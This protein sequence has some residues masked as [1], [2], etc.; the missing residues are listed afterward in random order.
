M[1][2]VLGLLAA[3]VPLSLLGACHDIDSLKTCRAPG[4]VAIKLG[5]AAAES[6]ITPPSCKGLAE[7]CG[8]AKDDSCCAIAKVDTAE[9]F[10]VGYDQGSDRQSGTPVRGFQ[11]NRKTV[12]LSEFWLDRYEVTVGRFRRFVTDYDSWHNLAPTNRAGR[13]PRRPDDVVDGGALPDAWIYAWRE[14]PAWVPVNQETLLARVN[15]DCGAANPGEPAAGKWT[16]APGA[17]EN[18]PMTCVS[19]FE[20]FMFCIWD[21]A[22][23]PSEAEWSYAAT[24]GAQQRAF[25]WSQPESNTNVDPSLANVASTDVVEV[26]SFPRGA[27]R[28]SHLDLA[29]NAFEW[30]M[31]IPLALEAYGG[32]SIDPVDVAGYQA[33]APERVVR[34]GSFRFPAVAARSSTRDKLSAIERYRDVGLR[35]VR[36]STN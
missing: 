19:W 9:P 10:S 7:T 32:G 5:A 4:Q 20:A 3:S 36:P 14:N 30:V 17:N 6:C 16:N 22:R 31:D 11:T 25:P 29:G 1:R 15:N 23:L 24:G 33:I 8:T 26:G 34:G 35:C 28:F 21:G 13:N 18:Q 2:F 12:Q 27:G